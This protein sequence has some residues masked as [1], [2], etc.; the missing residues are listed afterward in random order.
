MAFNPSPYTVTTVPVRPIFYQI[1]S[2]RVRP[3]LWK[4][5]DIGTIPFNK[6]STNASILVTENWIGLPPAPDNCSGEYDQVIPDDTW[7]MRELKSKGYKRNGVSILVNYP[8]G[9]DGYFKDYVEP[10]LPVGLATYIFADDMAK[11]NWSVKGY[12][13]PATVLTKLRNYTGQI[14]LN[15]ENFYPYASELL[16]TDGVKLVGQYLTWFKRALEAKGPTTN[17]D[18]VTMYKKVVWPLYSKLIA[19]VRYYCPKA[20][21]GFY[22]YPTLVPINFTA[23]A[24][25]GHREELIQLNNELDWLWSQVDFLAPSHYPPYEVWEGPDGDPAPVGKINYNTYLWNWDGVAASLRTL[26][27]RVRKPLYVYTIPQGPTGTAITP[28]TAQAVFGLIDIMN[29][30]GIIMWGFTGMFF[31]N[32]PTNERNEIEMGLAN[33]APFLTSFAYTSRRTT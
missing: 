5:I 11:E 28:R 10:M 9:V 25:Y 23:P 3:T 2:S 24:P 30:D 4:Y 8:G 6:P 17:Q 31:P 33:M 1:S 16:V 12:K 32:N 15:V 13:V 14:V 19:K 22:N 21:I 29:P 20:T 27:N 7:V 18:A 26:A